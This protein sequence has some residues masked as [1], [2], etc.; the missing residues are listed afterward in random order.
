MIILD[1]EAS[2]LSQESYPIEIAWGTKDNVKCFLINPEPIPD[3]TEWN[4]ESEKIHNIPRE[5]LKQG[6]PPSIVVKELV[7]DLEDKEVFVDGGAFDVFWKNRLL[8]AC[9]IP[10]S[11]VILSDIV[12]L[13]RNYFHNTEPKEALKI[14]QLEYN[15][16]KSMHPIV[17]RAKD[18]VLWL[19]QLN[20]HL[21]L[22]AKST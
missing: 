16:M 2:S 21:K 5:Q 3:W 4:R 22:L 18:D 6:Y 17:H 8:R 13:W 12:Q 7:K 1:I 20:D 19:H 9:G 10:D 14:I 11:K 15:A